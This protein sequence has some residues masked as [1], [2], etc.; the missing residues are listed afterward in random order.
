MW[1]GVGI[2]N[3]F[4]TLYRAPP[5]GYKMLEIVS[6]QPWMS[7]RPKKLVIAGT[8]TMW[9]GDLAA[10]SIAMVDTG[11]GPVFL[12]DPKKCLWAGDWPTPAPLPS[13]IGESFACQATSDDLSITLSDDKGQEFTYQVRTAMLPPL[14][15]G[16]T[17]V[18][19]S[20]CSFMRDDAAGKPQNGM[21]IG[22]LSALFNYVLID[23]VN[24]RV[25]LKAKPAALV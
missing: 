11:G 1:R 18:M 2:G 8:E 17:L 9:P 21:N 22:G 3:S 5:G 7:L 23:Y 20:V 25:G 15:Q 14:A 13:W 10:S 24:A 16:L 6:N 12:S 4:L 19:C